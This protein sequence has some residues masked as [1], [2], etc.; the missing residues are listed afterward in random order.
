MAIPDRTLS[1]AIDA[2][3]QR[4]YG[5]DDPNQIQ[6]INSV[7]QTALTQGY[8][9]AVNNY[10][11]QYVSGGLDSI[12][13]DIDSIKNNEYQFYLNP[14]SYLQGELN[15]LQSTDVSSLTDQELQDYLNEYGKIS[16]L[17]GTNVTGF[18]GQSANVG[19]GATGLSG[20]IDK[21]TA[22]P[23]YDVSAN[24]KSIN[25][26]LSGR[27]TK[28]KGEADIQSLIN[29][30]PAELQS[31]TDQFIT[32][33]QARAD[34]DFQTNL[35]PEVMADLN[36]RG[37]L[38][39]GSLEANLAQSYANSQSSVEAEQAAQEQSD[40]NFWQ[41]AGY[42]AQL[43]KSLQ[44]GQDVTDQIAYDREQALTAQKQ[45]FSANQNSLNKSLAQDLFNKQQQRLLQ[46]QQTELE[47]E[48]NKQNAANEASLIGGI[49]NAAASVGGAA[50]GTKLAALL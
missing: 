11:S 47:N 21:Q 1:Q 19:P 20:L 25:D 16:S 2:V 24:V 32:E 13:N 3:R 40:L 45:N 34:T 27:Q 10:L 37:I 6:T 48:Q 33:E 35:A 8:T 44:A 46:Q 12:K 5:G 42:Q 22:L 31:N 26:I 23:S 29:N 38:Q 39:S 9:P 18:G 43:E 50:A 28:A 36:A 17:S 30:L 49:T 15:K 7:I 41:N 4:I 14:Q